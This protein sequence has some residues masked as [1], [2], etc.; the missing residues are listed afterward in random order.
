M[1]CNP[2]WFKGLMGERLPSFPSVRTEEITGATLRWA[3]TTSRHSSRETCL[4]GV[5]TN[6]H[7]NGWET[8]L[9][10]GASRSLAADPTFRQ[11]D[12]P[13]NQWDTFLHL[14]EGRYVATCPL[15]PEEFEPYELELL[16]IVNPTTLARQ[17]VTP[18]SVAQRRYP[19]QRRCTSSSETGRTIR[20]TCN[21]PNAGFGRGFLANIEGQRVQSI[22]D[23]IED[24]RDAILG[25]L[26]VRQEDGIIPFQWLTD[27]YGG[28]WMTNGEIWLPQLRPEGKDWLQ[29][30]FKAVTASIWAGFLQAL[31]GYVLQGIIDYKPFL[32][33]AGEAAQ[34]PQAP[35]LNARQREVRDVLNRGV[36][37]GGD[38]ADEPVGV[39]AHIV[40]T[41]PRLDPQGNVFVVE[42]EGALYLF[43]NLEEAK[44]LA[45]C[46]VPASGD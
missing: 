46:A 31:E 22:D 38:I 4:I 6:T 21:T 20:S 26:S 19:L 9:P 11:P 37:D 39:G 15:Q 17:R 14:L 34:Q 43:S 10:T 28:V 3:G 36:W 18:V 32:A 7:S 23:N 42:G 27:P 29:Y 45:T 44:L 5:S 33:R 25:A 16:G 35:H 1:P 8:T 24:A 2:R 12:V 40:F 13:P 41:V 30:P